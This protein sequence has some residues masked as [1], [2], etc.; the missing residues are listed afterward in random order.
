VDNNTESFVNEGTNVDGTLYGEALVIDVQSGTMWGYTAYNSRYTETAT[1]FNDQVYFD[2]GKD[3]QGEVIDEAEHGWTV[4]LPPS[5]YETRFLVTPVSKIGQRYRMDLNAKILLTADRSGNVGGIYK[6]DEERVSFYNPLNVVCTAALKLE[7][8]MN[9][10]AYNSF[11]AT[12]NQGWAYVKT[13]YGTA[14]QETSDEAVIGKL[15]RHDVLVYDGCQECKDACMSDCKIPQMNIRFPI[16][17]DR[18]CTQRCRNVC[19]SQKRITISP[20]NF[21]WIRSSDSIL[22]YFHPAADLIIENI[23]IVWDY[24]DDID[25]VITVKNQGGPTSNSLSDEGISNGSL[26]EC[27]AIIKWRSSIADEFTNVLCEETIPA[28]SENETYEFSCHDVVPAAYVR[29]YLV[30]AD[31]LNWID[32]SNEENNTDSEVVINY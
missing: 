5:E 12:G 7:D 30:V 32:E 21:T 31:N 10:A 23:E 24:P 19:E 8:M 4:V 25:V 1:D 18:I 11:N 26:G 2:D 14:T 16:V 3:F 29:E 9:T 27:S 15:E 6:N 22:E 28:L 17:C 20:D 13:R